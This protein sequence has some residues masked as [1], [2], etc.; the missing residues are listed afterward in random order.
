MVSATNPKNFYSKTKQL[1]KA[2]P[3]LY[4][5]VNWCKKKK[6]KELKKFIFG[7]ILSKNPSAR[8][9]RTISQKSRLA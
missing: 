8:S 3:S 7:F 6:K 1:F 5:A 9:F 4:A 2:I